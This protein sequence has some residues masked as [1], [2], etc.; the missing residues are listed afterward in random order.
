MALEKWNIDVV[1][2][3]VGFSVRHLMVSKVHG[4]FTQWTGSFEFDEQNPAQSQVEVSI[5]AA[6]VDTRQPQ[7]DAH[8]RSGDFFE[9]E[10]HP[11]ILF[12]STH[13]EPASNGQYKVAGDLTL[14]GVTRPVT[15]DV[16]L[17]GRVTHPQMGERIG[18]SGK[19]TINR[20]EFGVSFNQVLDTGGLGLGEK[21]EIGIEIEATRAT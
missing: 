5:D 12:K 15:L 14:R 6:S 9:V 18:F 2:S 13:V 21:V 10:K 8:L 17:G 11:R 16:E 1:H 20:K 7:R 3:T 4:V 19:T